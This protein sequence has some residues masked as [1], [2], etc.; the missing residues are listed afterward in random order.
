M[1]PKD[2]FRNSD[3]IFMT[4]DIFEENHTE[5]YEMGAIEYNYIQASNNF[6]L[7]FTSLIDISLPEDELIKL[8]SANV[9]TPRYLGEISEISDMLGG[10]SLPDKIKCILGCLKIDENIKNSFPNI[11]EK[12]NFNIFENLLYN[13]FNKFEFINTFI[14]LEKYLKNICFKFY[15]N[16]KKFNIEKFFNKIITNYYQ[17]LPKNFLN[18]EGYSKNEIINKFKNI[19]EIRNNYLHNFSD[20]DD[21]FIENKYFRKTEEG[22]FENKNYGYVLHTNSNFAKINDHLYDLKFILYFLLKEF[23]KD[24]SKLKTLEPQN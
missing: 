18:T 6:L 4:L 12:F 14:I 10:I 20:I 21:Q 1:E 22:S 2:I 7:I 23:D 13:N 5:F 17:K 15:E 24:I 8:C 16:D 19:L 11:K 3:Y 9:W